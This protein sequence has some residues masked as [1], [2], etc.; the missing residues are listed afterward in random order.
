MLNTRSLL[1][2]SS[3]ILLGCASKEVIPISVACPPPPP[4]P[5]VLIEPVSTPPSLLE[6]Y[7]ALTK[8]FSESLKSAVKP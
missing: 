5:Q 2:L 8:A 7:E 4:L 1:L 6:R 3:M